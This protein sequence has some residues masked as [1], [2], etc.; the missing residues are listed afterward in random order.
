MSVELGPDDLALYGRVFLALERGGAPD[1]DEIVAYLSG[2][3]LGLEL[4]ATQEGKA[5]ARVFRRARSSATFVDDGVAAITAAIRG[6]AGWS[7]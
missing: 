2:M 5:L 6:G 3:E 7:G 1:L 4:A